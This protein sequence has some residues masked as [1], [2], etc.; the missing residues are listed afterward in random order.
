[1]VKYYTSI[2][3]DLAAWAVTQQ[4]FFTASAPLHGRH[5]N[6]SPKGLPSTSFSIFSPN[7][8]GYIDATGSG[9]ETISHIRENGRVTIMFCSFGPSP[10]I[11]RFFC[12]GRV[13]EWDE[14]GFAEWLGRI[15]DKKVDGARAV[16]LLDVFKVS[17]R[18]YYP[19]EKF[20]LDVCDPW[21]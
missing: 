1:M 5:I 14:E 13:V 17:L 9:N 20:Y 15:G 12:R 21:S 2:E 4:V 11:L 6:I 10:R 16:I 18:T 8:C 19:I 3:P 7:F